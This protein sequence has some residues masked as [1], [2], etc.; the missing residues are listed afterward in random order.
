[1]IEI[2]KIGVIEQ[3]DDK[4]CQIK[5]LDDQDSTGGFL[6][7]TGKNLNDPN[8]EAFDDW[9]G[10]EKELEGYFK[11]SNWVIRWLQ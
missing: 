8:E 4:G 10:S 9:V 6:I 7:I 11:E 2:G 3:G 1:M 5:V